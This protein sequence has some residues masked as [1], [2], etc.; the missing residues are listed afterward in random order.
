MLLSEYFIS[1][2]CAFEWAFLGD[3]QSILTVIM[4]NMILLTFLDRFEESLRVFLK[5]E[6]IRF[7]LTKIL[8]Y[9]FSLSFLI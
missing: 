9:L 5:E 8:L 2:R 6:D 1:R 4:R 3:D 7:N